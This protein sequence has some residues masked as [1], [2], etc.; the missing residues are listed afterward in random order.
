MQHNNNFS[1]PQQP[2]EVSVHHHQQLKEGLGYKDMEGMMKPTVHID[3]FSS[4]MGEDAD[5]IVVSF[6]VRDK[7]AAKDLMTW[8]E[9]GYDFVLD[10]DQSPGEIKPNRYLVYLEMRRRNAAPRQIQEILDDL[11]T[12]TE[13]ESDDWIMVYK[14]QKH[15]WDPE[16]FAELVPLTPNEYRERT[17]GDLN[18]MRIAAGLDVKPIYTT[19]SK[20]LQAMQSAAGI[21]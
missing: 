19:V 18:E 5:V 16:T 15:K 20:D 12:L 9:K 17:E 4:K 2:Q 7:Q 6:F 8:F 3:E 11:N 13:Y 1:N 21:L 14:K 10:A